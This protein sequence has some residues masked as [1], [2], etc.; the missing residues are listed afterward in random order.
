[1]SSCS[2]LSEK[3]NNVNSFKHLTLNDSSGTDLQ[4]L[5]SGNWGKFNKE[6]WLILMNKKIISGE[7]ETLS[8]L[9]LQ[10][11]F[12]KENIQS[13][14]SESLS[15]FKKLMALYSENIELTE[16][17][18]NLH[19]DLQSCIIQK[20]KKMYSFPLPKSSTTIHKIESQP[21]K[22]EKKLYQSGNKVN[23]SK[24]ND[25]FSEVLSGNKLNNINDNSQ[26]KVVSTTGENIRN[27][28]NQIE[29]WSI[30]KQ[31]SFQSNTK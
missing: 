10:L 27:S 5:V 22:K 24:L 1:M 11:A 30:E 18:I 19:K 25:N 7:Y 31:N 4:S 14:N 16:K 2:F 9:Q 13:F 3:T 29:K 26:A 28:S 20:I 12:I 17:L 8:G 21:V 6:K 15:E 23:E